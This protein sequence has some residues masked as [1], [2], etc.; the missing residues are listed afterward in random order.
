[1]HLPVIT[2]TDLEPASAETV[3]GSQ[4]ARIPQP[5]LAGWSF[6]QAI[7]A[8]AL[9]GD[10]MPNPS[11]DLSNPCNLNCPYCFVEEK[12]SAAKV[13]RP[14]ELSVAETISV[15]NEFVAASAR[16]INLVGA[17]EPTLDPHFR[18]IVEHIAGAGL[19]TVLFTNGIAIAEDRSLIDFLFERQVSVIL[20]FN[21]F[22]GEV[23]DWMTGRT[24]Y[25]SLRDRA[26]S[27][28]RQ[29]GFAEPS[30]TRLG[31]DTVA[32]QGN[33]HE[34][35]LFQRFCRERNLFSIVADYIPTGRTEGGA[36]R[37]H[38]AIGARA[39]RSGVNVPALL[40]PLRSDQR[41][42]LRNALKEV[43]VDFGIDSH[44]QCAYYSGPA[45]TQLLGMYVDISGN[46]WPCV[47]KQQLGIGNIPLGRVR[48]GDIIGPIWK[49]H[50]T[51]AHI[52][53]NFS[54][55]CPYKPSLSD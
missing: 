51:L 28:L 32:V 40:Q 4:I 26:L 31:L 30:P 45:C 17:G 15:I 5:L 14:D 47:A 36:F 52:R 55:A 18:E 25:T 49:R 23:Q 20:K 35:P 19:T 12:N 6:D 27:G 33:V 53:S 54:G 37:G 42:I 24:G 10:V 2:P 3:V 29:R 48:D 21:S 8:S 16:T 34:L 7:I 9:K 44:Q 39:N 38:A 1:M 50:P 11:L 22:I 13:R 43:D 46:I 41:V